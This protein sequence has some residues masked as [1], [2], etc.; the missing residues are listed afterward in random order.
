MQA[1][2]KEDEDFVAEVEELL[3]QAPFS[4]TGLGLDKEFLREVE[5]ALAI[6]FGVPLQHLH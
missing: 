4:D 2:S 6:A 5:A 3:S 1:I